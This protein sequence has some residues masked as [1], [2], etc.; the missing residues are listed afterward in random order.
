[1]RVTTWV[2]QRCRHRVTEEGTS[3][4]SARLCAGDPLTGATH[5]VEHMTELITD[6]EPRGGLWLAR[7]LRTLALDDLDFVPPQ[8]DG[9]CGTCGP[10]VVVDNPIRREV[11]H[12]RGCPTGRRP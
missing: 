11:R 5:A 12:R 8:P 7:P 4:V 3:R 6:D 1:M 2:C 10:M 9:Y